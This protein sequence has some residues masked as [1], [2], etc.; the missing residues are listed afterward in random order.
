MSSRVLV[1]LPLVLAVG[2]L[3]PVQARP[4]PIGQDPITPG[5]VYAGDFPD[6]SVMLV[7][8]TAYAYATTSDGRNVPLVTSTDL[9]TW[10]ANPGTK[11]NPS[12]DALPRTAAWSDGV[13]K[14]DG[15][16]RAT[17]WAPSV[18][19]LGRH[20]FVMAYATS[21][22]GSPY[23][24][25]CISLAHATSARGPFTDTT[26]KP[27]LCPARGAI[28]PQVFIAPSGYPWLV[29]KIDHQPAALFTTRMN[30]SG[31]AVYPSTRRFL[32]HITRP[33][34]GNIMEGPAMIRY[35]GRFYLFYS[36][37]S[38]ASTR[39]ATGYLI[40]R[41]WYGGCAKPSKGP[42]MATGK[43]LAGPGGPSP[44]VD[45]AGRLRLAYHAWRV[46]AVGYPSTD[47]CRDTALGCGQRRLYVATLG[48]RPDGTLKVARWSSSRSR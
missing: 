1:V 43:Y 31:T 32:A 30:A 29:W 33:W 12:G 25:M 10:R 21:V 26:T 2:L 6:P 19:R 15:R 8:G 34:E 44:F 23:R 14:A 39:Y 13:E 37:N 48:V 35:R 41:T 5:Q 24:R 16:F 36:A 46:G 28:D 17:T 18:A 42:L 38:Y 4:A 40:C 11:A 9:R 7:G 45:A 27:A 47:A 22:A 3:A 20:R